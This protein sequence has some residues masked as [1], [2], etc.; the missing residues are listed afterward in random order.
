MTENGEN[1]QAYEDFE[2][3]EEAVRGLQL[4]G[5]DIF[6]TMGAG[7]AYKVADKVFPLG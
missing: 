2:Q 5:G 3:A 4:H 7:E 6:V 1:A